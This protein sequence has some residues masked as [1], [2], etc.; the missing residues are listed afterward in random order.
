MEVLETRDR[1]HQAPA[2]GRVPI[3]AVD[4]PSN[5]GV[6]ENWDALS[7]GF[8][9]RL[10]SLE[11]RLEQAAVEIIRNAIHGPRHSVAFEGAQQERAALLA[12]VEGGVRVAH[13]GH[14]YP[15]S[16]HLIENVG[17]QVVVLER[18]DGQVDPDHLAQLPC[19]LAG[20]VD[21]N[22]GANVPSCC[23]HEPLAVLSL[24]ASD[25]RPPIDLGAT[26]QGSL[27]EGVG[28]AGRIHVSV[29]GRVRGGQDI[30]EIGQRPKLLSRFATDDL[31][32]HAD[33]VGNRLAVMELVYALWRHRQ[34]E[35]PT[36]AQIDCLS[37]LGFEPFV[38]IEAVLQ[39]FHDVPARIELGAEAGRV[40]GRAT[41]EFVRL[42]QHHVAPPELG[43][44]IQKAAARNSAT[45]DDDSGFTSH[46][47][48]PSK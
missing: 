23:A 30:V 7:R 38:Q 6:R 11:F 41:G 29:S 8:K 40:P 16:L 39:Q 20:R 33:R 36:A 19:P 44:V 43:Q 28:H 13:Y 10:E 48:I 34:A 17:N 32:R 42:D 22:L 35:A 47:L 18:H 21:D 5:P 24:D 45:N 27:G 3:R 15:Q 1:T 31:E 26:R 2:V 9:N 14:V 4:H 37:R 46:R 12:N 25:W